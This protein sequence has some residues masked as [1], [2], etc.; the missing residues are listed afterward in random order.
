MPQRQRQ[1]R[2]DEIARLFAVGWSQAAIARQVGVH[3][4][5]VRTYLLAGG[6]P[7]LLA[8][9][10]KPGACRGDHETHLRERWRGGCRDAKALW[11]ELREAGYCATCAA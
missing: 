1:R 4:I 9:G 10:P 2:Y 11:G 5:T 7:D 8:R 6:P 3:V